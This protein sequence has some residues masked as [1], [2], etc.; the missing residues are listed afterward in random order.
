MIFRQLKKIKSVISDTL[1]IQFP[2]PVYQSLLQVLLLSI[3]NKIIL[4]KA[5]FALFFFN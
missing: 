5:L 1:F 2:L 4:I 3:L